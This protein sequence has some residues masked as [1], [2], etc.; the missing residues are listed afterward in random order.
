MA[1]LKNRNQMLPHGFLYNE[2]AFGMAKPFGGPSTSFKVLV[3]AVWQA[4]K[5]NKYLSEKHNLSTDRAGVEHDVEQQNIARCVAHG[6]TEFIESEAPA[7][8]PYQGGDLKKNLFG[9]VVGGTKRVAAGIGVLLDWLGSG[10]K[11]VD[12]ATAEHRA[13]VCATCPKNDGGDWKAYFT[14]KVADKIK[15][16]LEIKNDLALRTSQDAKLTVC[17][18]CDCPLPLK[19]HTPIAHVLAHTTDDVKKRLDPR[20]WVLHEKP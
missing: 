18:A 16:Q 5:A 7:Y 3:D 15:T 8:V 20:C 6:W 13:N 1:R 19:V 12:Q 9:N 11:P 14:G 2:P 17:S 10:G 4:R